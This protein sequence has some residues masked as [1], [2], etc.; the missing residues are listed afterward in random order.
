MAYNTLHSLIPVYLLAPN[1]IP[2]FVVILNSSF[3]SGTYQYF[4]IFQGFYVFYSLCLKYASFLVNTTPH[5][6]S[7]PINTSG[8]S[9]NIT[10]S[11]IDPVEPYYFC[12]IHIYKLTYLLKFICNPKI[13]THSAFTVI[14][15]HVQSGKKFEL[16]DAH[17]AS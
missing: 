14:H 6:L 12:I 4:F 2:Y 17:V 9:L 15:G 10:F 5:P 1:P 3:I 7:I 16:S 8:L 11:K 13:N